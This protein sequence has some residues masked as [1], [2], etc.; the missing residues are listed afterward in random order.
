MVIKSSIFIN[1][2]NEQKKKMNN[3]KIFFTLLL[4]IYIGKNSVTAQTIIDD[5]D[6]DSYKLEFNSVKDKPLIVSILGVNCPACWAHRDDIRDDV[7]EQ[8]NNPDLVWHMLWFEDY[9]HPATRDDAVDEAKYVTDPRAK[10]WWFPDE[11]TSKGG[12]LFFADQI[13]YD[14]GSPSWNSC[15]YF[16]DASLLYEAGDEWTATDPPT[17]YYCMSKVS[18]CCNTYNIDD[19]KS[20]VDLIDVCDSSI[21]SINV[22]NVEIPYLSI[23]PNPSKGK[24]NVEFSS[25]YNE[26]LSINIVDIAGRQ[27]Y[28]DQS[29]IYDN[30]RKVIDLSNLPDGIYL[31]QLISSEM[32]VNKRI[33]IQ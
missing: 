29:V 24:F 31:M 2:N 30:H 1:N 22:N 25:S 17:P 7:M 4:F 9:A 23:Y 32:L 5:L 8:C 27:V 26:M 13:A 14:Y 12:G 16:W 18:G 10:Q 28:A 11:N 6:R 21:T 3:L 15:S 20:M 19:F 33:I